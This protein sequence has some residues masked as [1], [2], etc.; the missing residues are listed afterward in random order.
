LTLVLHGTIV[1]LVQKWKWSL[2]K[3]RAHVVDFIKVQV[4]PGPWNL[5]LSEG[6]HHDVHKS[7]LIQEI[8]ASLCASVL[9]DLRKQL[10]EVVD[11]KS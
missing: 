11:L 4:F 5:A 9:L 1:A 2:S 7:L 6:K 10:L 8:I 3:L